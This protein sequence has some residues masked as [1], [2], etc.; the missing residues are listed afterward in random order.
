MEKTLCYVKPSILL[1]FQKKMLFN[2]RDIVN[3]GLKFVLAV[4]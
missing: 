1:S 4:Q 2:P 3:C